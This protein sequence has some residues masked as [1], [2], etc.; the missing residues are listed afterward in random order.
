MSSGESSLNDG[1]CILI[2][3][4]RHSAQS[5]FVGFS[6]PNGVV[7]LFFPSNLLCVSCQSD[8]SSLSIV[9]PFAVV[10][11]DRKVV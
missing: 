2:S 3:S 8:I 7:D 6:N 4:L 10:I 11:S 9:S 5:S 1:V